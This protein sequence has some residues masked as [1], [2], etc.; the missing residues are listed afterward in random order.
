MSPRTQ[1]EE[2]LAQIWREL[3]RDEEVGVHDNFF[4]LGGHS[5]L[6][7]GMISRL[8]GAFGLELSLRS[9]FETPTIAGLAERLERNRDQHADD[10]I[11]RRR[12]ISQ[13]QAREW[14]TRLD[15][16]SGSEVESLLERVPAEGGKV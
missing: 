8:R 10:F 16:L 13:R 3:L 9:I 12:S 2:R 14:M 11:P 1:T 5:L 4:E 6:A 15:E 7:M